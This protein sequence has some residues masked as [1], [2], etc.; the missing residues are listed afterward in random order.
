MRCNSSNLSCRLGTL[1]SALPTIHPLA[2]C[3]SNMSEIVWQQLL[4]NWQD[5][6]LRR[7][8]L[9]NTGCGKALLDIVNDPDIFLQH[10]LR[11][12]NNVTGIG[13]NIDLV[14]RPVCS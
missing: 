6:A 14:S 1:I 5:A 3:S 11:L 8:W 9:N 2:R 12:E 7:V 4:R 10:L 13:G